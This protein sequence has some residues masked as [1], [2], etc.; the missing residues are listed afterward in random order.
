MGL[1]SATGLLEVTRVPRLSAL[2]K[3]FV[4]ADSITMNTRA[5]HAA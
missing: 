3:L 1:A 2:Q 5:R 4:A